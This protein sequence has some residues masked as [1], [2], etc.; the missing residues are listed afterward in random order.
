M[1]PKLTSFSARMM[2][3][4][5][6]I[7]AISMPMLYVGLVSVVK[8]GLTDAFVDEVRSFS[9]VLADNLED[10]FDEAQDTNLIEFLDS[11][12]LGGQSNY[13]DIAIDGRLLES[14]LVGDLGK[15]EFREDFSFGE[16]GDSTYYVS[17]PLVTGQSMGILRLGFDEAPVEEKLQ[18][19][20]LTILYVLLTYLVVIVMLTVLLSSRMV[21]PIRRLKRASNLIASGDYEKTLDIQSGVLEVQELAFDLEKMRSNLVGINARL[22]S[23]IAER[24]SAEAGKKSLESK[25][26]H[27]Q[28]LESLGTL[29]GGVAHEFNNVLQPLMLYTDLAIDDLP[30]DSPARRHLDRVLELAYDAKDL[31]QQILTFGR[32]GGEAD[33][34]PF[35]LAPIV[36]EALAMVSALLPATIDIVSD[37]HADIGLVKCDQRQIQQLVVNLCS[38]AFQSLS[39]GT[40]HIELKYFHHFVTAEE[41]TRHHGLH[42]GDH[43]VIEVSD[44]GIGMDEQTKRRIFEPF[45]TT[46]AVGDGTGL[47]LSVVHGIV[48]RHR[49]SIVVD[50]K[51]GEGSRFR[52]Y[53]PIVDR[54]K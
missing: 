53:L 44:T 46:Q 15:R 51:E 54:D 6:V 10:M 48:V 20:H 47:G 52:V 5:L 34:R 4:I 3:M 33:L 39:Q 16:N 37:I 28:R 11:V 19:A 43:A 2:L 45:Y 21:Q 14:S 41:A 23:E 30:D 7:H 17:M 13:A 8:K 27:A 40:G 49:G 22:K 26:R 25:L 38:N 12:A 31:S 35:N 29:A 18:Q 50:S 36:D 24:E 42:A 32:I 9:R 1:A